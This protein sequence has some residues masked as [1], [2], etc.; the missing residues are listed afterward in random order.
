[1]KLAIYGWTIAFR[2][3]TGSSVRIAGMLGKFS[4]SHIDLNLLIRNV[5]TAYRG[6]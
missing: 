3:S 2:I 5:N 1:V 4:E 6:F